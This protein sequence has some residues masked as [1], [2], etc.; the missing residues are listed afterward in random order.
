MKRV[1]RFEPRKIDRSDYERVL[2]MV[3]RYLNKK[4]DK[5]ISR[6]DLRRSSVIRDIYFEDGRFVKANKI[7]F[8]AD[9]NYKIDDKELS[10]IFISKSGRIILQ[11]YDYDRD[12]FEHYS[13]GDLDGFI[14]DVEK[15]G[16]EGVSY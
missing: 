8:I 2:E 6:D 12:D 7:S 15:E 3:K 11:L 13:I 14:L 1:S 10:V 9:I 5:K 16:F 4:Y